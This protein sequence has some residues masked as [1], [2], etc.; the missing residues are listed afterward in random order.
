MYETNSK[1]QKIIIFAVDNKQFAMKK[2]I[3]MLLAGVFLAGCASDEERQPVFVTGIEI[4]SGETFA[5]GDEVT[6]RAEGF[7]EGDN[8]M[9]DIRWPIPEEPIGEGYARGVYAVLTEQT[10]S[11]IS[12]L[13]PGGYPAATVEVLLLRQ[14]RMQSLG[15]IVVTD[16]RPPREALLYGIT[17][18]RT[19][20]ESG[21]DRIDKKTGAVDRIVE[22]GPDF[23]LRGAVC[24]VGQNRIYGLVPADGGSVGFFFD[25]TMRYGRDS[26]P[27]HYLLVG[28]LGTEVAYLC[29]EED[30][31]LIL[32][33]MNR[34]RTSPVAPPMWI[35][36]EGLTPEMLTDYPFVLGQQG[37]LLLAANRGDGTFFPVALFP[38]VN[39]SRVVVGEPVTCSALIPFCL[40]RSEEVD[41]QMRNYP[42]GGYAVSAAEGGQSELRLFDPVTA[43]F[44][45]PFATVSEPILSLAVDYDVETQDIYCLL[46]TAGGGQIRVSD[47]SGKSWRD[48]P[49]A[50]LTCSQI[51]LAR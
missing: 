42:V 18:S 12:F 7:R 5:P 27:E 36:P 26:D 16:G 14:G 35:L 9:L 23:D 34:T 8:I 39:G 11:G 19:G 28:T 46:E 41:G 29:C 33:Q 17:D 47:R 25:L 50:D 32:T 37:T 6:V 31:L 38:G 22:F 24:S 1:R 30:R 40:I 20:A 3:S 48:L 21:I 10:A 13:A 2:L 49:G 4:P 45:V 44:D 43:S 15:K 51:V